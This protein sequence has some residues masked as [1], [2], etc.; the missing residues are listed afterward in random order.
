MNP[1]VININALCVVLILHFIGDF[2]MQSDRMGTCKSN[3]SVVLG[4]HVMIYSVP[5]MLVF[6]VQYGVIN[7]LMHF[8]TDFST[9]RWTSY[10]WK[11]KKRHWFFVVIGLDQ[12]LHLLVLI[13]TYNLFAKPIW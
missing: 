10:L 1:E 6:G 13:L 4:E 3:N 12:L 8:L 5:L 9:S 2:I 7:G 11:K